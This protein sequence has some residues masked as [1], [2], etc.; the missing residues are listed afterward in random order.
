MQVVGG[1]CRTCFL[2][3]SPAWDQ[4]PCND[5]A[6]GAR[7]SFMVACEPSHHHAAGGSAS[8]A[9]A[10][11]DDGGLLDACGAVAVQVFV[12]QKLEE[13]LL[14]VALRGGMVLLQSLFDQVDA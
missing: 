10:L 4:L 7:L 12:E 9:S 1:G 5:D 6:C 11:E 8:G 3:H 13:E 2:L 14:P